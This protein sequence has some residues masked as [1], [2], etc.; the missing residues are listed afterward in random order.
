MLRTTDGGENWK[1]QPPP[2]KDPLFD[3]TLVDENFGVAVGH[4]N[5]ILATND[6]GVTWT[7]QEYLIPEDESDE[8]GFNAVFFQDRNVGWAAGEFGTVILTADGGKTW[9]R[10][11]TGTV[12]PLYSIRFDDALN[13]AAVGADG[14]IILT[15]DG[16]KT[17]KTIPS[18]T[19]RHLFDFR[20]RGA[21]KEKETE[22]VQ[23]IVAI[24]QEGT[25]ITVAG[26]QAKTVDAGIYTWL[27]A[28]KFV[29]NCKG[30]A[31][32]GRGHMLYT[33]DGGATWRK[34]AGE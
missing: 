18:G 13:G 22:A 17:W 1:T 9:A 15:S 21:C 2:C 25:V 8:P 27:D 23:Y 4:F 16:G 7:K 29:D 32:G 14:T 31:V 20:R 5:T 33:E 3:V 34:T 28:V 10:T 12:K 19:E 24:G 30:W 26:E 6:G 11:D